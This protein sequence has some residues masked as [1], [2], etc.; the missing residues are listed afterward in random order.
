M[1]TKIS[2]LE[3]ESKGTAGEDV[4]LEESALVESVIFERL[5]RLKDVV[6]EG[7]EVVKVGIP[8][9][10]EREVISGLEALVAGG[11]IPSEGRG[12]VTEVCELIGEVVRENEVAAGALGGGTGGGKVYEAAGVG[13]IKALAFEGGDGAVLH[14]K[15][16]EGLACDVALDVGLLAVLTVVLDGNDL[17]EDS[18]GD[19]TGSAF[20][21][22]K[23]DAVALENVNGA[24]IPVEGVSAEEEELNEK[25]VCVLG[26]WG[27]LAFDG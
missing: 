8:E 21:S 25:P 9:T 13:L 20:L 2:A 7:G 12:A 19:G 11:I 17:S 22:F 5:A 1:L 18:E 6:F 16:L 24:P 26:G 23:G 27:V 14:E 15:A 10:D 4:A 3:V